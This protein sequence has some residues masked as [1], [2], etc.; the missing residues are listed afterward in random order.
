MYFKNNEHKELFLALKNKAGQGNDCEYTSALYVLAAL[1]KR[2][3][4]YLGSDGIDFMILLTD[5]AQVGSS[6]E[7]ALTK[8]AASLFNDSTW[9]VPIGEIFRHL[10]EENT[11]VAIEAL[12]IRY[13][14]R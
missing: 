11:R 9:H 2:V 6:S 13:L 12:K 10:D 3:A 5:I 14:V 7:Q 8:L 1:G 4:I